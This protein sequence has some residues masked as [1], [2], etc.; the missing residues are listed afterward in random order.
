MGL[1][2]YG[3]RRVETTGRGTKITTSK[4]PDGN[5]T[6]KTYHDKDGNLVRGVVYRGDLEGEHSHYEF[7]KDYARGVSR[8]GVFKDKK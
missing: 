8:S 1:T 7:G 6:A 3:S 5:Y 4:S 2:D